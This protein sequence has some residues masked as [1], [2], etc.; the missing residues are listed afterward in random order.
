MIKTLEDAIFEIYCLNNYLENKF[1]ISFSVTMEIARDRRRA[2]FK[3][4][5][6]GFIVQLKLIYHAKYVF[7]ATLEVLHVVTFKG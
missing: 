3:V 6:N 4:G 1:L 2:V 5:F 7:C